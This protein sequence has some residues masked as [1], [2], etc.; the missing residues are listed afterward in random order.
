[1]RLRLINLV[2]F[3]KAVLSGKLIRLSFAPLSYGIDKNK[4]L[5]HSGLH[6]NKSQYLIL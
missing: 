2:Y 4:L 3:I 1:M 5:Y 6:N